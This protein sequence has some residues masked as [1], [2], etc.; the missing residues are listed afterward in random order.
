MDD[1]GTLR[2]LIELRIGSLEKMAIREFKYMKEAMDRIA[3]E[4]APISTVQTLFVRVDKAEKS[5]VEAEKRLNTI[6]YKIRIMWWVGT[7]VTG[8]LIATGTAILQSW[9][10]V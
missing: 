8:G 6:L 2:E 1:L 3:D 7:V 10:G 9:L 5:L 4:S